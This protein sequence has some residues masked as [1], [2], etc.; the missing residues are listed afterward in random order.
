M[1]KIKKRIMD[2]PP[3]STIINEYQLIPRRALGQ[4]FI[5]DINLTRKIARAADPLHNGTVLEIG[6][7][8]GGLTRA[9]ILE[10]ASNLIAIEKDKRAVKALSELE[11][12]TAPIL[13][14]VNDDALKLPLQN[15]GHSPR[16][17]V[18]NLPYNISTRLILDWLQSPNSFSVITVMVQ[19]EVANRLC[20]KPGDPNYGRLAVIVRWLAEPKLLFEVSPNAFIP[21]PKV[22]S[23]IVQIRPRS[24]PLVDADKNILELITAA[25]FGQ[26]RKMLRSSLR[27]LGGTGLLEKANIK[28]TERPENLSIQ[29]FCNLANIYKKEH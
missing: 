9:L 3:L 16:Q 5:F 2:L 26:R 6:P 4:N 29:D 10:G 23:A 8:P 24:K 12:I 20:A 27:P 25:A 22:T 28:P 14:I 11:R 13:T 7:G 15:L 19:K 17:I 18:A 1:D 21:K